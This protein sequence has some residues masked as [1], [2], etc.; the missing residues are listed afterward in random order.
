[1][2]TSST[3]DR[4]VPVG[5]PANGGGTNG[6]G[7]LRAAVAVL[8]LAIVGALAGAAAVVLHQARQYDDTTTDAIVVL[9]ASLYNGDPSPV[10]AHRLRQAV[11]QYQ[12]GVAPR[13]ITVGGRIPGDITTEAQAGADYL[14]RRG[15]PAEAVLV[16][17]RGKDTI[18]SLKAISPSAHRMGWD[19]LT[20][21]SDRTHLARSAA[22]ADSLGFAAH[23]SGP[24]SGDG[25][26]L[27]PEYVT[28]E[29]VGLLRWA[30]YDRWLLVSRS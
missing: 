1:M 4:S 20:L 9:G 11:D 3:V 17:P 7:R 14:L 12:R 25:A 16:V 29:S 2:V 18:G 13:I 30:V 27:T 6:S 19:A 21:V 24:A 23:V 5:A 8:V 15:V 10:F 22:I 28:R 26:L